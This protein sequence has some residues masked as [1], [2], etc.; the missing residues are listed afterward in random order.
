MPVASIA[1]VCAGLLLR[2]PANLPIAPVVTIESRFGDRGYLYL[3]PIGGTALVPSDEL[4]AHVIWNWRDSETLDVE[5]NVGALCDVSLDG[6]S[7]TDLDIEAF[8]RA[9]AAGDGVPGGGSAD[10]NQDGNIGTDADIE[11][12]FRALMGG[13]CA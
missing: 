3:V 2:A 11:C 4:P 6:D 13:G 12:F 8:F 5:W 1:A 10:F 7:G 9:L